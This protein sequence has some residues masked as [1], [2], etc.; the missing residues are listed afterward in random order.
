MD[1][2]CLLKE[3]QRREGYSVREREREREEGGGEEGGVV[4]I[5]KEKEQRLGKIPYEP[6]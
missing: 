2:T 5:R 4:M 1:D 3:K 6:Q